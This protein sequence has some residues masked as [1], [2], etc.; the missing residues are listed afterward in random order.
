MIGRGGYLL[1]VFILILMSA[2]I[3]ATKS[4]SNF[5][6]LT[7]FLNRLSSFLVIFSLAISAYKISIRRDISASDNFSA[8][9]IE[10]SAN[11]PDIYYLILDAYARAD[12]L[13]QLYDFD[14]TEFLEH[15][16]QKGFYIAE[17]SNANYPR[18]LM[19]LASSLNMKY[20]DHLT[21]KV[22]RDS[23]SLHPAKNMIKYNEVANFL[24]RHGYTF[25][26][27]SSGHSTTEITNA[28]V[29]LS[30]PGLIS[31]FQNILLN[32]TPIPKLLKG[33]VDE[34]DLHR[35]RLLF[36]FETLVKMPDMASPKFVFAH[37]KSPHPPFVFGEGGEPA[38]SG[39]PLHYRTTRDLMNENDIQE[40]IR[41]Y[42]NQ[43]AAINMKV[44]AAVDGIL[45]ESKAPPIIILQGD[46]GPC[47]W[48]D[49]NS[50][51]NTNLMERMPI[52]NAYYLP[53]SDNEEFYDTITPVN[54]FRVIFNQYFGARFDLLE[55]EIY[56]AT[57]KH[58]Y[59]FINVTD[60][61]DVIE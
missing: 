19:S 58:P 37:I 3:R 52:L 49:Y 17:K 11:L 56:F 41:K 47:G 27:F 15:L 10:K 16:T 29:Y 33:V 22:G 30:K 25:V 44:K 59:Q 60:K 40:Y 7:R 21:E 9:E 32:T 24:K 50:L 45:A 53:E 39:R 20:L 36:I 18:T 48:L 12:V 34:Y 5:S 43:L 42:K 51:E 26:A 31:E 35:E 6:Q 55:D 14:N 2:T 61:I 23:K 1:V 28:D 13:K 57:W 4:R 8:S 54:T 38:K 46:H